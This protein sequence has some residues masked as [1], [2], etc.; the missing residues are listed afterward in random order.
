MSVVVLQKYIDSYN[1]EICC[2]L[3]AL[4]LDG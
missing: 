3:L 2:L 4:F 1:F